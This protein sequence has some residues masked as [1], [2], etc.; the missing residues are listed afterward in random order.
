MA[1]LKKMFAYLKEV[2]INYTLIDLRLGKVL[3]VWG[4]S[5]KKYIQQ[6]LFL[7]RLASA[8]D[9]EAVAVL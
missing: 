3:M 7:P 1:V 8:V 2:S 5:N 4:T 9:S 6:L